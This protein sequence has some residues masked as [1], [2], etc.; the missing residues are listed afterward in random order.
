MDVRII[1][2]NRDDIYY[3]HIQ[4]LHEFCGNDSMEMHTVKW[5]ATNYPHSHNNFVICI[6]MSMYIQPYLPFCKSHA[7]L[8]SHERRRRLNG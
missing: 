7:M 2:Y 4:N 8:R 5:N 3:T 6:N 1:L